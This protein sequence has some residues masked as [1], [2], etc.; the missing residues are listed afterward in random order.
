MRATTISIERGPKNNRFEQPAQIEDK[1][2]T[3][4]RRFT[5]SR[6]PQAE[7]NP[8]ADIGDP[9]KPASECAIG[10]GFACRSIDQLRAL[11]EGKEAKQNVCESLLQHRPLPAQRSD[12]SLGTLRPFSFC[13]FLVIRYFCF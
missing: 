3:P 1:R 13:R 12:A 6:S 9:S 10:L 7:Q 5:L 2:R 4:D 8:N 11:P